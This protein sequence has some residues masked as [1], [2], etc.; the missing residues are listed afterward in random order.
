M[1][2]DLERGRPTEI[3]A[4]NGW[5]VRRGS[6][7]GVDVPVNTTLTHFIRARVR[8]ARAGEGSWTH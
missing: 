7:L 3:E 1:L 8:S 4:I 5:V 2:Q 6:E